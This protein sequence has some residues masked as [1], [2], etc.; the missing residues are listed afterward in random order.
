MKSILILLPLI[1]ISLNATAQLEIDGKPLSD[2]QKKMVEEQF[3]KQKML[4][5]TATNSCF[6]ID[7]ISI[8]NKTAKEN[9][10]EIKKCIDKEVVSYQESLTIIMAAVVKEGKKA[11]LKIY[12]NPDS[13]EYKKYYYEIEKQ[14]MDSCQTIKRV[15]GIDNKENAKSV[16]KKSE[17]IKEFNNGN[18]YFRKNEYANALPYFEKAVKIDPE[19]VFAWD[20]IGV[21]NRRLGNYDTAIEAYQ[22]SIELDPTAV[23]A[24]QNIALAY[25]GKKNFKKAI[26]SY[27]NLAKLDQN[28]PEVYYGIG[29]IYYENIIDYEQALDNICKAYNLYVA[30][31]SPYRT[32]AEKIIQGIYQE[33][34]KQDKIA[35]FDTILKNNNISQN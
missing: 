1:L 31:N 35:T 12:T 24:H 2:Q 8:T 28:N 20:N 14:L 21:C 17:A 10:A 16:S 18:N 9:A 30:Q 29:V 34:K 27:Q 11:T 26:E 15:V 19:F 6:C 25:I 4:S 22:K 13:N 5:K 3:S 32:D 7:S 23:T 33:L